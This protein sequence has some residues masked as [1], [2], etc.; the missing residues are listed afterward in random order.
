MYL[1]CTHNCYGA[2]GSPEVDEVCFL[3]MLCGVHR[4]EYHNSFTDRFVRAILHPCP[5]LRIISRVGEAK[6]GS[7]VLWLPHPACLV[8]CMRT[9]CGS[10]LGQHSPIH[11]SAHPST[12]P[13]IQVTLPCIHVLPFPRFPLD[14]A[15]HFFYLT[16]DNI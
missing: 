1:P 8:L 5:L 4:R 15:R 13:H 16:D 7:G 2:S 12:A 6:K 11:S 9:W 10:W 3:F 14:T